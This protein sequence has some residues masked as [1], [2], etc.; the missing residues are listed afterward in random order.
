MFFFRKKERSAPIIDTK[1]A[2]AHGQAQFVVNVCR[3]RAF[4]ER[5]RKRK[6]FRG[7]FRCRGH[8]CFSRDGDRESVR[9]RPDDLAF[10]RRRGCPDRL[11]LV[12]K[13][14]F[15]L[16]HGRRR[17]VNLVARASEMMEER[18]SD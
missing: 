10:L 4:G 9:V 5:R 16:S 6:A 3:A 17:R 15:L 7:R 2:A 1:T 8:L 13:D 18:G 11:C 12:Q 14:H